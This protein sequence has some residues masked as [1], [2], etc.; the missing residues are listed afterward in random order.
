MLMGMKFCW[1]QRKKQRDIESVK[2]YF[3]KK[4]KRKFDKRRKTFG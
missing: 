1:I 2:R 4:V 3:E